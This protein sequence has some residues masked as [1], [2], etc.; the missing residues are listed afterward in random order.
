SGH[1]GCF[2][3]EN[4]NHIGHDDEVKFVIMDEADYEFAKKFL[5]GHI[6][7]RTAKILFSPVTPA[8]PPK[9]LAEWMLRDRV[10]ARLQLQLHAYIWPGE[11]GR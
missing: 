7:G 11:R 9:T 10:E 2:L 6:R 4:L 1:A 5:A 8:L 3:M